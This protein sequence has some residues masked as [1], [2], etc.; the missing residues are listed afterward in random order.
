VF[1]D[2]SQNDAGKSTVAPCSLRGYGVP[3]VSTPL[4][5]DEVSRAAEG[6]VRHLPITPADALTRLDRLGDQ[7]APVLTLEQRLPT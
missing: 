2:W 3:T 6:D 4:T 7:F 5:W 1:V